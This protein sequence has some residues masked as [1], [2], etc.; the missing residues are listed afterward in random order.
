[1]NHWARLLRETPASLQRL[2]A[3]TQ[4]IALP[5]TCSAHERYL[6]LRQAL[7]HAQTVRATYATLDAATQAALHDLCTWRGGIP[8]D[9]LYQHYGPVRA[10]CQLEADPL[11]RSST[12]RLV[13]L[14]WLLPRPAASQHPPRYLLPPELRRW[15]PQPLHVPSYGDAPAPPPP[16]ALRAAAIILLACAE[17]PLAVCKDG[18]LRR[19]SLRLLMRRLPPLSDHEVAAIARFLLPLLYNLGFV[20][21]QSGSCVLAPAGQRFLATPPAEQLTQLRQAWLNAPDPDRWLLPLLPDRTGLDW[22]L[23]RRRLCDWVAVLPAG[24]LLDLS[25]LYPAL[26]ATFGPLGDAQTHGFRSV[27][28]APWQPRR[29]ARIFAAALQGPL[30][31]LGWVAL[32]QGHGVDALLSCARI[33]DAVATLPSATAWRYGQPGAVIIPHAG[34]HAT[35]LRLLPFADWYAANEEI[36]SYLITPATLARGARQGWSPSILW[37]LL[38]Q[39]A[40]PPPPA[41]RAELEAAPATVQITYAAVVQAEPSAVLERATRARSVRRYL[42]A[43]LAAGLA[44]VEPGHVAPLVRALQRQQVAVDVALALPDA[45]PVNLSPAECAALLTACMFY[46]QYAPPD[47]PLLPT[48]ALAERLRAALPPAVRAATEAA[49]THFCP[50]LH[51]AP[52]SAA[53]QAGPQLAPPHP[54]LTVT[55]V[56]RVVRRALKTHQAVEITYHAA[57]HGD[58]S[59]RT[60]YPLALEQCGDSWYLRAYC[61][62]RGA[63]RTFRVDR[64]GNLRIIGKGPQ[65]SLPRTHPVRSPLPD[66]EVARVAA[67]LADTQHLNPPD[68][69]GVEQVAPHAVGVGIDDSA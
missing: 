51:A 4:R 66:Q 58:G 52:V 65:R 53:A 48:A 12:E 44:L 60:V 42:Q 28:R 6:R 43:R 45:A 10:W 27:D 40:G 34:L 61:A 32:H 14:G 16:P 22:P 59:R 15:L 13:L 11:P 36:T 19:T 33:A 54:P 29:A 20:T 67:H 39:H 25:T 63:E 17:Q 8:A 38:E 21:H 62:L 3:R 68:G 7:C 46:R 1:M 47:A 37:A 30:S 69:G 41:W 31:W 57:E 23:L 50:Q 18:S 49:L 64:I 2:I 26:A 24:R 5:R 35:I 55:E 9:V 56:V